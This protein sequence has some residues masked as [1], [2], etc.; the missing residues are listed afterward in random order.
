[1][2]QLPIGLSSHE[3][4]GSALEATVLPWKID[5]ICNENLLKDK[6]LLPLLDCVLPFQICGPDLWDIVK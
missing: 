1:M 6:V 5:D 2:A 3:L 4:A